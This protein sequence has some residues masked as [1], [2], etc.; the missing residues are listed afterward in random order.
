MTE[1]LKKA[2]KNSYVVHLV[3]SH[4]ED[5]KA[6]VGLSKQRE[7]EPVFSV[8]LGKARL[9]L[10]HRLCPLQFSVKLYGVWVRWGAGGVQR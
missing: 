6:S 3:S 5:P 8:V 2:R 4:S 10:G 7:A 1:A 9:Q